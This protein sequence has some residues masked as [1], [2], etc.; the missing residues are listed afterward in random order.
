LPGRFDAVEDG[1]PYVHQDDVGLE[2]LR[3][4]YRFAA[5]D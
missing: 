4:L 3:Q 5:V 2:L 1:H